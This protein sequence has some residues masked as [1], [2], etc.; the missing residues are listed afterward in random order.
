MMLASR[1]IHKQHRRRK[2]HMKKRTSHSTMYG[3]LSVTRLYLFLSFFC[4]KR[5]MATHQHTRIRHFPPSEFR[6]QI[7]TKQ[8]RQKMSSTHNSVKRPT[9]SN[10]VRLFLIVHS[11]KG[12][13]KLILFNNKISVKIATCLSFLFLSVFKATQLGNI[14]I[15]CCAYEEQSLKNYALIGHFTSQSR[16]QLR[17]RYKFELVAFKCLKVNLI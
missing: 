9:F 3:W 14:A 1:S 7:I 16:W 2:T 12:N 17:W 6:I 10:A 11:F 4:T 15:S 5:N 13:E 8:M